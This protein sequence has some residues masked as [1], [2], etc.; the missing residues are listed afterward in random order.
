[1]EYARGQVAQLIE[2]KNEEIVFTSCGTESDNHAIIGT[3]LASGS[4]KRHI[5]TSW[6]GRSYQ[7]HWKINLGEIV[8]RSR[9]RII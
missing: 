8:D 1:M 6:I 9:P 4:E 3:I 7:H 2:A 5:I